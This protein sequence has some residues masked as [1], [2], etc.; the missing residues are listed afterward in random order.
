MSIELSASSDYNTAGKQYVAAVTGTSRRWGLA[1]AFGGR[2]SGKRGDVTTM[3]VTA[4]GLYVEHDTTRRGATDTY[5]VVWVDGADLRGDIVDLDEASRIA[6]LLD[7][8]A[9]DWTAVGTSAAITDH[10]RRLAR[11][12]G[13]DP[14]GVVEVAYQIGSLGVG[15]QRRAD[16][17]AARRAEIRRLRGE[18]E[19]DP[20]A[21]RRLLEAE[22]AQL[23]ARLA[24]ID[25]LLAVPS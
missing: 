17:I 11:S 4:P 22:R 18:V 15:T 25:A 2:K 21:A 9:V 5:Y 3:H 12:E 6:G 10:E 1:L 24:E 8:G 16:V 14:E 23:A 20:A 13:K 19:S 7:S